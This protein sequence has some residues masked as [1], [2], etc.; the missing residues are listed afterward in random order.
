[1]QTS[2]HTRQKYLTLLNKIYDM[3]N[4]AEVD[5]DMLLV[6]HQ[7]SR[8]LG[9]Y[10][11][12]LKMIDKNGRWIHP[13]KPNLS[14]VD[15]LISK[16]NNGGQS[17][18][19]RKKSKSKIV[20]L[21]K[22]LTIMQTFFIGGERTSV[23]KIFSENKLPIKYAKTMVSLGMLHSVGGGKYTWRTAKPPDLEMAK[24]IMDETG[25][26][27]IITS[28]PSGHDRGEIKSDFAEK[29]IEEIRLQATG[30]GASIATDIE[31]LS[32]KLDRLEGAINR[33][34]E[35]TLKLKQ[36]ME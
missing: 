24:M 6:E 5:V 26:K 21:Y 23:K 1:M 7:A 19:I 12:S 4:H 11:R 3:K 20:T 29:I 13:Q 31:L 18:A 32:E 17:R 14:L 10:A 36:I 28:S 16:A 22:L 9:S 27:K 34:D 15:A 8:A 35:T 25:A 30:L 33:I 2:E